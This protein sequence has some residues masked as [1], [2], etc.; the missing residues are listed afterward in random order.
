MSRYGAWV[1]G[2]LSGD[3]GT[4]FTH[5]RAV[6]ELLRESI[7]N[8][9]VLAGTAILLQFLLGMTGGLGAAAV[10]TRWLDRGFS[11]L[12][13]V[14]YSLP[15][16]WLGLL[17]VWLFS[18]RLGWL[19]VSQMHATVAA[20]LVGWRRLADSAHHLVL[21]CLALSL[22]AASGI[23]L[24]VREEMRTILGRGPTR[25]ARAR[26]ATRWRIL[27][28]HSL[29]SALMPVITLLGLALPGLVGGSVVVEVLFAWPGMGRLAYEAVLARDEPLILG[30]ALVASLAVVA[31]SLAADL[32]SAW[33]DPRLRERMT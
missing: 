33:A 5:R 22:P 18:V 2:V 4:S 25:M 28:R 19:P 11:C 16:Y 3:L 29:R 24:Y 8:T 14:V 20:S 23:A 26:G 17:M 10:R 32:F 6:A 12:A 13:S 30:C 7:G 31:G 27:L 15:S 1:G 9:I 21:P